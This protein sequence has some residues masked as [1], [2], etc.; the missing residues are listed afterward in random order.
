MKFWVKLSRIIFR[1]AVS[2][3][4]KKIRLKSIESVLRKSIPILEPEMLEEIR[5]FVRSKQTPQGG[6]ADRA[7]KCD[8]YYSLFGYFLAEA[9]V[10][11][12]VNSP[13]RLYVKKIIRETTLS[14][15]NLYCGAI[16]YVKL[17]GFDSYTE[18]LKKQIVSVLAKSDLQQPEYANFLGIMALY[19]LE[20]FLSIKRII[21]TYKSHTFQDNLPCPVLA[22][23][24][25]LLEIAGRTK[26]ESQKKLYSFYR[27]KGGFAAFKQAPSE[28]L[29]STAVALY[30]LNFMSADIR[31][32]KPESLSFIDGL[33]HNG[34][35]MSMPSDN[36]IDVEY[37]FY[38]LL[39]LGSLQER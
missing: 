14:G 17:H 22:A 33:Y 27:S 37:T 29:L 26:P 11:P 13:F 32:I 36:E 21:H 5:A 34:G 24:I 4:L 18:R 8:L 23:T 31:L 6:F 25:L 12:E 20:D 16:L 1:I 38:G 30:A 35:F 28:D 10:I 2:P 15:V 3:W 7:G 39:A 9:L 19:Y